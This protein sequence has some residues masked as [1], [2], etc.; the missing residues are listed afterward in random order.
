MDRNGAD[1]ELEGVNKEKSL[2]AY[3][4]FS[5]STVHLVN[6]YGIQFRITNVSA[7]LHTHTHTHTI[8]V[9]YCYSFQQ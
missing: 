5:K 4:T 1:N 8:T 6:I 9:M 7:P 3:M 2:T